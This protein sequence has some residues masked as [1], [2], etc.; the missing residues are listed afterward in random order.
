M[1]AFV[2]GAAMG[3]GMTPA[4]VVEDTPILYQL[5][6]NPD[7]RFEMG[8]TH[9][10]PKNYER[11][12]W[13]P[14][15]LWE[16]LAHSRN[17][18]AVKTLERAGIDSAVR[19]A[20]GCGIESNIPPYPSLA[21]G[22][23]D[24]T[25]KELTRGYA[26][27]A[28]GGQRCP[29]PFLIRKV[30][31]RSG[32]VLEEARPPAGPREQEIDPVAGFQLVQ[33]LQGVMLSGTAAGTSAQL[34]WPLAGKTGT[35]DDF[36][37]AWFMGFSTRVACGVWVG[38]DTKKNIH[39][40]ASGARTALPIWKAFM[41][42]ILKTTAKEDFRPPKGVPLEWIDLD[43]DTGLRA[44]PGTRRMRPMAFRPGTAPRHETDAEAAAW[45]GGA[46]RRASSA[47]LEQRIWGEPDAFEER[48]P[49]EQDRRGADPNDY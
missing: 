15:T 40:G 9:Y 46:R 35:T 22:A 5:T 44:G 29:E 8:K 30:V 26:T 12:F 43:V 34:G 33:M 14:L 47:P 17:V 4:T 24:L 31:D 39:P 38:M 37:D 10:Q 7:Q 48:P 27:I 49:W 28:A 19:F 32:R 11:D 21:L 3:E 18:P 36:T 25:L 16:A 2:Y 13:G 42:K 45:V 20:R 23:A 1:K 6:T 41:G